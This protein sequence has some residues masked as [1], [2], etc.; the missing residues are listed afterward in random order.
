M[1]F[2]SFGVSVENGSEEKP[3]KSESDENERGRDR[4]CVCRDSERDQG[5]EGDRKQDCDEGEDEDVFAVEFH[6]PPKK[7]ET[8][9]HAR[10]YAATTA[11][12][13]SRTTMIDSII[14]VF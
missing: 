14:S 13:R 8:I 7:R 6:L 12:T 10:V 1:L 2:R 4:S 9:C 11:R 3:E 5:E